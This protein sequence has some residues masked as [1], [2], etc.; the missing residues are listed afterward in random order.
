V[1]QKLGDAFQLRVEAYNKDLSNLIELNPYY[2]PSN[3]YDNQGSGYSRGVEL[4]LRFLPTDRFFGWLSYGF[5]DSQRRDAPDLPLHPYIYD[6]PN[7]LTAVAGYKPSPGWE[8]GIKAHYAT[9]LPQTPVNGT[10]YYQGFFYPN[11]GPEDSARLPDYFR[12]DLSTS[13]TT[14]YDTWLWKVYLEIW[15]ATDNP[16]V[17][18]YA[19]SSDFSERQAIGEIPFLPYLGLE[20]DF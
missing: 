7:E 2:G 19:Y 1:E 13:L 16:N 10:Y 18:A 6:E 15:N 17:L 11:Y 3:Y 9:G 4:F 20:A 12:L 5:S 8:L 14:L